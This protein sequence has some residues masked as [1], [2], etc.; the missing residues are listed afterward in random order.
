MARPTIRTSRNKYRA[1][2]DLVYKGFL[3]TKVQVGDVTIVLKSLNLRE[4]DQ[5][6]ERCPLRSAPNYS[7]AFEALVL[8]YAVFRLDGQNALVGR[9]A[10]LHELMVEM[11]DV[12]PNI[13]A[14]MLEEVLLLQKA[15]DV[16]LRR[17]EAYSYEPSSRHTWASYRGHTPNNPM[18][19]GIQG[20]EHLG[21]NS[22]QRAWVYLNTEEDERLVAEQQWG[23]AKFVASA[24][25]SKGVKKIDQKDKARLKRLKEDRERIRAG[26][27][28]TGEV[29]IENRT[30]TDLHAQLEADIMG[31]KDLHDQIVDAYETSMAKKRV[32][33]A[34]AQQRLIAEAQ[35]RRQQELERETDEE[36][37]ARLSKGDGFVKVISR[38]QLERMR[39]DQAQETLRWAKAQADNRRQRGE[40]YQA[41]RQQVAA[42][43]ARMFQDQAPQPPTPTKP[44]SPPARLSLPTNERGPVGPIDTSPARKADAPASSPPTNKPIPT[45]V[46][47][48]ASSDGA[49]QGAGPSRRLVR[50]NYGTPNQKRSHGRVT[51]KQSATRVQHVDG[52][53]DFFSGG[54]TSFSSDTKKR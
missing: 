16:E 3:T 21:L 17:L 27:E 12:P 4:L 32:E 20:T 37:A 50:H 33:R 48:R 46:S 39:E 26:E 11:L 6:S 53:D 19:T 34:Q 22:H 31:K 44:P 28:Y 42:D 10:M 15:Q 40:Q 23:Y 14:E 30:V 51:A 52:E 38:D 1:V 5:I 29:R 35:E 41:D 36:L 8:S 7:T 24:A 13:R 25:N 54:G 45:K 18:L 9:P 43:M 2:E 47:T 49:I